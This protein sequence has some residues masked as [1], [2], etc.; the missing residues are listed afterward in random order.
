VKARD[1]KERRKVEIEESAQVQLGENMW[2]GKNA[3]IGSGKLCAF[4]QR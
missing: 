3:V 2:K 1:N 4:R